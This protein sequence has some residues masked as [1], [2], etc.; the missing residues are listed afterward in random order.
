M[1]WRKFRLALPAVSVP[2]IRAPLFGDGPA[3]V[4]AI[5]SLAEGAESLT[6]E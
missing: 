6:A 3:S 4:L 1:A 2:E 5:F